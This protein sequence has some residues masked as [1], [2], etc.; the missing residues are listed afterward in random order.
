MAFCLK[1]YIPVMDMHTI[2]LEDEFI[3]SEHENKDI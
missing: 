3:A 2:S 1:D